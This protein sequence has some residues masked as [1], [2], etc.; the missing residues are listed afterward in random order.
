MAYAEK[1]SHAQPPYD[2][3][4]LNIV[5]TFKDV[6]YE[7]EPFVRPALVHCPYKRIDD[8]LDVQFRLLREDF[9]SPL[10][11]GIQEYRNLI[12]DKKKTVAKLIIYEFIAMLSLLI[13]T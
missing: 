2:F 6:N 1:L 5:P 13:T 12:E 7:Q 9:V 11:S 4:E 3:R 8:Y 10:R